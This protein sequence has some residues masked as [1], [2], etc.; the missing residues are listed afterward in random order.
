MTFLFSIRSLTALIRLF[1]SQVN[2]DRSVEMHIMRIFMLHC[3]G[4]LSMGIVHSMQ[5]CTRMHIN[6]NNDSSNYNIA[7]KKE[8]YGMLM[9][10]LVVVTTKEREKQKPNYPHFNGMR[11][12]NAIA[13]LSNSSG[14]RAFFVLYAHRSLLSVDL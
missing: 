5:K 11:Y 10:S 14:F 4:M 13:Q 6:N 9:I 12:T 2:I 1:R 7:N 3:D 8:S